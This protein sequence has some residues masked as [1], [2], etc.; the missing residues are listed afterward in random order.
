MNIWQG[1]LKLPVDNTITNQLSFEIQEAVDANGNSWIYTEWILNGEVIAKA[2]SDGITDRDGTSDNWK[3]PFSQAANG[4][5]FLI[6]S[7]GSAKLTK[8][9]Y[10][11][12]LVW[13]D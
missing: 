11:A 4:G 8:W 3:V 9:E 5:T 10:V 1:N 12:P 2:T 6:R 13:G 7:N